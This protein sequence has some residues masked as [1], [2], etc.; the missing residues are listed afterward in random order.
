MI[1]EGCMMQHIRYLTLVALTT[2]I[3]FPALAQQGDNQ[4]P[5][6]KEQLSST[7]TKA[8]VKLAAWKPKAARRLLEPDTEK[9]ANVAIFKT[10]W[11]LL[12]AQE[13]NLEEARSLLE[14]A[15]KK[16][17]KD[18]A[19]TFYLGEVLYWQKQA[20]QAESAWKD[21]HK[22]AKAWV[23]KNPDD[24]RGQYYLGAALVRNK[25][26]AEARKPLTKALEGGFSPA[27][28]NYQIGLSF[29]FSGNWKGAKDALSEVVEL[30]PS[31]AHA[32]FYRGMAWDKLKRKDK[33]LVDMDQF[34][35]LANDAPEASKARSL[36]AAA[37]R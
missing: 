14:A 33:M 7:A 21:A 2:A 26:Y 27:M 31:F 24:A 15:S 4:Q 8:L 18:P 12:K 30:D 13:G 10:A 28:C 32:Y 37:R 35:K 20:K 3:G 6:Q 22:R 11:A 5:T 25:Q 23:K 36:L 34:V 16:D 17:N 9:G 29:A 19:P 1:L